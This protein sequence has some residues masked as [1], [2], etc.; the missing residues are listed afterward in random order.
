MLEITSICNT[1]E[2]CNLFHQRLTIIEVVN[3]MT[4]E[5]LQSSFTRFSDMIN[6]YFI[7]RP[8]SIYSLYYPIAT[9]ILYNTLEQHLYVIILSSSVYTLY[10]ATAAFIFILSPLQQ[11]YFIILSSSIYTFNPSCYNFVC[12]FITFQFYLIWHKFYMLL[13]ISFVMLGILTWDFG[14]VFKILGFD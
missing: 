6:L 4:P 13:M 12:L 7:L 1:K 8:Y 10:Y 5:R 2:R 11:L 14:M 9:F 3:Q